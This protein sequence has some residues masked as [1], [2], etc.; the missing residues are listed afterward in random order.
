M[1]TLSL[2]H[3]PSAGGSYISLGLGRQKEIIKH[4]LNASLT[5]SLDS[6]PMLGTTTEFLADMAHTRHLPTMMKLLGL[7]LHAALDAAPMVAA[8]R[9]TTFV[10][11]RCHK[12]CASIVY[13][14]DTLSMFD[15]RQSL[16][17]SA[18]KDA[19]KKKRQMHTTLPVPALSLSTKRDPDSVM[20]MLAYS[21]FR[22]SAEP[23]P[24][25]TMPLLPG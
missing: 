2:K 17:A 11:T 21:H 8:Q 10:R 4:V 16:K 12:L 7:E 5:L 3:C 18:K 25:Y 22:A 9:G 19:N 20:A 13:R 1:A 15:P 23:G 14:Y 24:A 6:A